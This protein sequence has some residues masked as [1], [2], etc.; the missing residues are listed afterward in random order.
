MNK[1][2]FTL[3]EML[4]SFMLFSLSMSIVL[5]ILPA[6]EQLLEDK[7]TIEEEIAFRQIR[8]VILLAESIIVQ[9]DCLNFFYLK[10]NATL[11]IDHDQL[12]KRNGY[13]LYFEGFENAYFKEKGSCIYFDYEKEGKAYERFLGCKT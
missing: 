11:E 1:K 7:Q 10:E 5:G 12:V 13:V 8:R 2:G 3:V 4:I 9:P 6:Y